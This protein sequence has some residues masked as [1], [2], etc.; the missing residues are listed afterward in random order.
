MN[1]LVLPH[2]F[3]K[4][5]SGALQLIARAALDTVDSR[6]GAGYPGYTEGSLGTDLAYHNGHHGRHVGDNSDRTAVASGFSPAVSKLSHVTG[7]A[8]DIVQ[9]LG[10]GR[11]EE[12]SAEWLTLKLQELGFAK[13]IAM[14]G[15]LAILG[16]EPIFERNRII[17]QKATRL[18]YPSRESEQVALSVASGDFGEVYTPQGPL[19]GHKLW[20]EMQGVKPQ[21]EP[22]FKREKLIAFQKN[23]I[24]LFDT[25]R[26]P[27]PAA[28]HVLATH[29]PQVRA[30]AEL[31]LQQLETGDI[32]SWQQLI[33]QDLAFMHEHTA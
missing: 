3:T 12:A 19:L 1:E 28:R 18:V 22:I 17:G 29:E 26:Y 27:L 11:D 4:E 24:D 30:Y 9:L 5:Q 15:G 23:Q 31:V 25:Y 13:G 10:R 14:I 8:H 20:Q 16:T 2:D 33:A 7:N 6:Y 21:A 32:V